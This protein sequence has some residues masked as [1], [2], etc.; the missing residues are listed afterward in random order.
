M[1]AAAASMGVGSGSCVLAAAAAFALVELMALK[2]YLR[3]I[4][5]ILGA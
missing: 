4:E 5:G 1:K 3:I 2:R